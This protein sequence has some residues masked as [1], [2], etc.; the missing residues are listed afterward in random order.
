MALLVTEPTDSARADLLRVAELAMRFRVPF[1]VVLNKADL[2]G[3][4]A[5]RTEEL[6]AKRD[7]PLLGRFP[8]LEELPRTIA[9]REV[10]AVLLGEEL[11]RLAEGVSRFP[12]TPEYE[13]MRG[14]GAG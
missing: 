13:R 4:G 1:G 12:E 6:C 9:R 11:H 3:E 2:S 14:Q 10:P 8:F 5:R 7:W